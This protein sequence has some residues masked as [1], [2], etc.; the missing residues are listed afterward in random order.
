M[1]PNQTTGLMS[2]QNNNNV[3]GDQINEENNNNYNLDKIWME[4][5]GVLAE[6][7]ALDPSNNSNKDGRGR[8]RGRGRKSSTN[9]N[10]SSNNPGS[11]N[12]E[13]AQQRKMIHR[14]IERQR[15]QEMSD[16]CASLRSTLP[17]EYI[18]GKRATSDH[19][20]G[21]VNYI[22]DLEKNVKELSNKRDQL[23]T[24]I[25]STSF[26]HEGGGVGGSMSYSTPPCPGTVVMLPRLGGLDI[27]IN[28]GYDNQGF[29]LS[30]ALQVILDEGLDIASYTS[31]KVDD[32]LVHNIVCEVNDMACIDIDGL[33]HRLIFLVC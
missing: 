32:R 20:A 13:D 29:S 7:G 14:E 1:F 8:G 4:N 24:S 25:E 27:E 19:L 11:S 26:K 28:V 18:K 2:F 21:A 9:I 33:H 22:K 5:C 6:V 17:T 15:R 10:S 31:T 23:R 30:T 3:E 16:L 12:I